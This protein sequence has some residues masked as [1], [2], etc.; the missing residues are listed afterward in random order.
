MKLSSLNRI[1]RAS[2]PAL[3]CLPVLSLLPLMGV[4]AANA[5]ATSVPGAASS[6]VRLRSPQTVKFD[7]AGSPDA[8]AAL[9]SGRAT[10]TALAQADLNADGAP[11]VVAGYATREGGVLTVLLGNRDAFAPTD[12][13]LFP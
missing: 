11:D 5:A 4:P 13:S 3:V 2:L 7:Y 10:P 8:V 6:L 9:G 12:P 1:L